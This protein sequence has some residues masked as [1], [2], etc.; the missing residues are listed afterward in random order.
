MNSSINFP[1]WYIDR[2]DS[3]YSRNLETAEEL[4]KHLEYYDSNLPLDRQER[5]IVDNVGQ[6]LSVRIERMQIHRLQLETEASILQ[7]VDS[8]ELFKQLQNRK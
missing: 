3:K 7:E 2:L 1:L 5:I 4:A 8:V 6:L